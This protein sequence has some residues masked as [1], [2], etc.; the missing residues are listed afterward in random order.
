MV[1]YFLD[2]AIMVHDKS[3]VSARGSTVPTAARSGALNFGKPVVKSRQKAL[4]ARYGETAKGGINS[5]CTYRMQHE[6]FWNTLQ[7]NEEK[8]A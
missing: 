1:Q 7:F 3:G 5:A 6:P 8:H 4:S 2:C